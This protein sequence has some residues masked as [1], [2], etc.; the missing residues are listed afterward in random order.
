[1]LTKMP[2]LKKISPVPF[3][4]YQSKVCIF[5]H[6]INDTIF[7]NTISEK[8]WD[9]DRYNEVNV[10][11]LSSD[12]VASSRFSVDDKSYMFAVTAEES[13][14]LNRQLN[15]MEKFV[16]VGVDFL[17]TQ[18][19][20][21]NLI[22]LPHYIDRKNSTIDFNQDFKMYNIENKFQ[23]EEIALHELIR[24]NKQNVQLLFNK[25]IN[26]NTT[27]LSKSR[28]TSQKYRIIG[29]I[30]LISRMCIRQSCPVGITLRLSDKLTAQ[31]DKIQNSDDIKLFIEY[32]AVEY[33]SLLRNNAKNY[34][35]KCIN[36][37]IE[38]ININIYKP[39]NNETISNY[40]NMNP[41][42]LSS[43]F[44]HE[45]GIPLRKFIIDKKVAESKYLLRNTSMSIYD[46]AMSLHF[47]NQS[48][49]T[50]SFKERTGFTPKYYQDVV[51]SK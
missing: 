36:D 8:L 32:L 38:F 22:N 50:K 7:L 49:F 47:S 43:L 31:L 45:T 6:D 19:M 17:K 34:N 28:L 1:M 30:T 24:G 40:L 4:L 26:I 5:E 46:I 11:K 35:S 23:L 18:K 13:N 37:A 15:D 20:K 21:T 41:S 39:L 29:L 48:H 10:L 3:A 9:Q 42:Y 2:F 14:T 12:I 27:P 44:K 33:Y 25:L 51:N 16:E